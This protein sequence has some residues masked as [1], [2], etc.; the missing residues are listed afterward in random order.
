MGIAL[1]HAA[2]HEGTG[3]SFIRIANNVFSLAWMLGNGRPL[4][5]GRIARA[6]ATAEPALRDRI[7]HS[8]RIELV[9]HMMKRL[10]ARGCDVGFNSLGLDQAA[11]LQDYRALMAKEGAMEVENI[12]LHL[13]SFQT[14]DDRLGILRR[15]FLVAGL[16]GIDLHGD[17]QAGANVWP[18]AEAFR[19]AADAGLGLRAHAGEGAGAEVVRDSVEILNVDRIGHGVRA[20]EETGLVQRLGEARVPLDVCPTSNVRTGT[21][22]SLAAH[23]IRQFLAAGIPISVSSDD[24]IVFETSVTTELAL[25][26]LAHGFTWPELG[27]LVQNGARAAFLPADER[28]ALAQEI[29]AGWASDGAAR[30]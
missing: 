5:A 14:S 20:T 21:V 1:Q 26:H 12:R 30:S 8:S 27:E 7:D 9:D 25:L 28:T 2:I 11:I 23:P 24:P 29:A 15:N 4:D 22:T 6:P 17:E 16:V 18:F 19:L 13:A 3:V 10:V